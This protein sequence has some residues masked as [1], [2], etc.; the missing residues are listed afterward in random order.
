M[1]YA[2]AGKESLQTECVRAS[3]MMGDKGGKLPTDAMSLAAVIIRAILTNL[4]GAHGIG[5]ANGDLK[6]DNIMVM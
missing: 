4:N 3:L 1:P 5:I 2:V 6:E